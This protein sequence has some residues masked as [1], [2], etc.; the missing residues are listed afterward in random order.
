[1]PHFLSPEFM[2]PQWFIPFFALVWAGITGMLAVLGGWSSLATTFRAQQPA[3]GERFRFASG[4]IGA[5]L[6][7]VS[8]GGCL[9][10]TVNEEGFGLSIL[11]PFRLLSPPLFIPWRD[12]KS[13]EPKQFLL[14]R[15]TVVR[16]RNHWP[17]ISLRG[18]AGE[19][20][21]QA[22]ACA[23]KPNVPQPFHGADSQ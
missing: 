1:M 11:F 19:R 17:N 6:L 9:F 2:Q 8:Y 12:V 22:Y 14:S 10:I 23:G 20:M 16:L 18:A 5:R 3:Q 7:P 15:Y 4:S 13:V 21:R